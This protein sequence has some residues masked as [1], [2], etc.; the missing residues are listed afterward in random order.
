M[1]KY[2]RTHKILTSYVPTYVRMCYVGTYVYMYVRMYV[3]MFVGTYV[4]MYVCMYVCNMDVCTMY[5]PTYVNILI[6]DFDFQ[7]VIKSQE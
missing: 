4:C 7:T 2:V 1:Y 6:A 5:V 3:C